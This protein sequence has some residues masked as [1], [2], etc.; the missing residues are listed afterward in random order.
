MDKPKTAQSAPLKNDP[1]CFGELAGDSGP[2]VLE[3]QDH[4]N[5]DT[6]QI[7]S[8]IGILNKHHK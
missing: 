3:N 1:K 4:G 7:G 8:A 2:Q 6:A 5:L